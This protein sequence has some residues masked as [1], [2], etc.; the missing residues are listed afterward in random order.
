MT[1]QQKDVAIEQPHPRLL[2][3]SENFIDIDPNQEK[4]DNCSVT[5]NGTEID[6]SESEDEEETGDDPSSE[7]GHLGRFRSVNQADLSQKKKSG[8]KIRAH[9]LRV[10]HEGKKSLHNMFQD[11]TPNPFAYQKP[12][13]RKGGRKIPN[14]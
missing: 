8:E 6:R 10:I 3:Q 4:Y 7:D 14:I 2:Q 9:L 13:L 5:T 12:F 1:Q 11:Q